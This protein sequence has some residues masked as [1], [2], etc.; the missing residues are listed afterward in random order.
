MC[1]CVCVC[2]CVRAVCCFCNSV[3]FLKLFMLTA[4][5]HNYGI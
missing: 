5:L 1:V 4:K 2:V 3:M